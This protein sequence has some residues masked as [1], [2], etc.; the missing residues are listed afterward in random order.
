MSTIFDAA[1]LIRCWLPRFLP[2]HAAISAAPQTM[3]VYALPLMPFAEAT[4]R[5]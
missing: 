1:M 4:P 3:P 2:R 5:R